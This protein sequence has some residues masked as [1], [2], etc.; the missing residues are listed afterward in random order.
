MFG[1]TSGS[2]ST[3]S[4]YGSTPSNYGSTSTSSSDPPLTGDGYSSEGMHTPVNRPAYK[5]FALLFGLPILLLVL[6]ILYSRWREDQRLSHWEATQQEEED[7][8]VRA[9]RHA[10]VTAA[11]AAIRSEDDAFS[12]VLLE[13][14]LYALYAE[15]HTARA[16]GTLENLAPYLST[17]ARGTLATLPASG[18]DGIVIGGMRT[19]SVSTLGATVLLDVVFTS[20]LAEKDFVGKPAAVYMEER[21][22]LSRDA[23][24]KSRPPAQSRV[25]G[26]PSCGA[27]LD[28]TIGD[29]C[30]Y[31]GAVSKPRELDW[32][33]ERV[34]ILQREDR[35]PMLTG[36]TEEVGTD[37]P[38]VVDPDAKK[39][40]ERL[41]A[42]DPGF[43]WPAFVARVGVVF[44]AF[45]TSWSSQD[46]SAVRPYL[47]DNLFE[48]QQ[49]WVRAYQQQGLR[50]QTESPVIVTVHLARVTQDRFFDAVTV[51]VF[52]SCLDYTTNADGQIVAGDRRKPREYSEYWTFI[53]GAGKSA[54]PR[55]DGACPSCGASLTGINMTGECTHCNAKVTNGEFDWVL[56]RI[57]QDE[58]YEA[59]A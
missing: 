8:V 2:G 29:T 55:S 38:T 28:K 10:N 54:T 43:L 47:S 35:G 40:L 45:H 26:C 14:F 23:S 50:N 22:R 18:I 6:F 49:Y 39:E 19:E 59:A 25:I 15:A 44:S 37:W 36:T 30:G 12:F 21:W 13:D 53:R 31:C 4:N 48:L 3:P 58:V 34:D 32:Y 51:R 20:N 7:A 46:L 17:F 57:E 27:P 52:A 16:N 24:A 9:T 11:L 42:R 1:S 5:A 41:R 56:S 33:V